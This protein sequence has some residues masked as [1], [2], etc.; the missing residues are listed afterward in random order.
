MQ[1]MSILVSSGVNS[2]WLGPSIPQS[3]M[4]LLH[5]VDLVLAVSIDSASS[6]QMEIW[7]PS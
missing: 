2:L 3:E 1:S 5:K 6:T 7:G 4:M